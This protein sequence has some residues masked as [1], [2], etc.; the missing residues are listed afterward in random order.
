MSSTATNS[1][2]SFTKIIDNLIVEVDLEDRYAELT[3]QVFNPKDNSLTETAH[4]IF[5]HIGD[6]DGP[7][8]PY[9]NKTGAGGFDMGPRWPTVKVMFKEGTDYYNMI[10]AYNR[11]IHVGYFAAVL[12]KFMDS[13]GL[14]W[15]E[16]CGFYGFIIKSIDTKDDLIELTP[17]FKDGPI[18]DLSESIAYTTKFTEE[19]F[20]KAFKK[21]FGS[22]TDKI[23]IPMEKSVIWESA[24][25]K[26][27][28]NKSVYIDCRINHK[29]FPNS[30]NKYRATGAEATPE[31]AKAS[32]WGLNIPMLISTIHGGEKRYFAPSKSVNWVDHSEL[33]FKEVTA[34]RDHNFFYGKV[35]FNGKRTT[36][37]KV[38][39][40]MKGAIVIKANCGWAAN[41]FKLP[42]ASTVGNS[43][44]A[45]SGFAEMDLD[46]DK[47]LAMHTSGGA[48][49]RAHDAVAFD[50]GV[51][52]QDSPPK[53]KALGGMKLK[54]TTKATDKLSD[55]E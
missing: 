12:R 44:G 50:D 23:T 22:T 4:P 48:P 26:G 41:V 30:A 20:C 25:G 37:Y 19:A 51:T 55:E 32:N 38:D 7:I 39:T 29:C 43:R 16:G 14:K 11:L 42:E 31:M 45:S 9:L 24:K 53:S 28:G 5:E 40:D 33:G 27:K 10:L 47:I 15:K 1:L 35:F 46:E 49:L 8:M 3:L 36:H 52:G 17:V 34:H 6:M 18:E 54:N 21:G 2:D 13:N